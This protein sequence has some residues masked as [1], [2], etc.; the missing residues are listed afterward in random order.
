MC[1]PVASGKYPLQRSL[2]DVV[3][4]LIIV[5]GKTGGNKIIVHQDHRKKKVTCV[6]LEGTLHVKRIYLQG[7]ATHCPIPLLSITALG[8]IRKHTLETW[9]THSSN[10]DDNKLMGI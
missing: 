6:L 4:S 5:Q 8:L 1:L 2:L 10:F 3:G 9:A 7:V